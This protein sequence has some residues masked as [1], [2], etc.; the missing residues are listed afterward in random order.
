[1]IFLF[2]SNRDCTYFLVPAQLY[3]KIL[4]AKMDTLSV[5]VNISKVSWSIVDPLSPRSAAEVMSRG[6]LS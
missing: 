1:M 6:Q 2:Y 4:S 5:L 3:H